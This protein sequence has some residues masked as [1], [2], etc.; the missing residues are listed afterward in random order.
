[1]SIIEH[2]VTRYG[3]SSPGADAI[4][5]EN[6]RLRV[7]LD[8]SR[9]RIIQAADAE[10]RRLERDLHD[11]AQQRLVALSLELKLIAL[12]LAPGS[13]T[14]RRLAAARAELQSSLGELRELARG[15]HPAVL[16][17]HGL[18]VALESLVARTPLPVELTVDLGDGSARCAEVAAYFVA[19]EALTNVAKYAR[20][21]SA[22]VTV[23][24]AYGRLTVE[25]ADDGIGGADTRAGSGLR[26]L[27][28]RVEAIGGRLS[29][30]SP[31]G[32][33]TTI[34]ATLPCSPSR[35]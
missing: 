24:R 11:G 16:V 17:N 14:E 35:P 22:A 4:A 12:E 28:D 7:E 18:A 21:T 25:I 3:M 15:L 27:A 20:A 30:T 32:E 29:I 19:A 23:V 31:I 10:R 9:A 2:P 26:G 1:M 33:G 6:A 13:E 34:S 5:A 8:S